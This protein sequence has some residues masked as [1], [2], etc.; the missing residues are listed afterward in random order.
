MKAKMKTKITTV[1]AGLIFTLTLFQTIEAQKISSKE[2][3][4][5]AYLV[6]EANQPDAHSAGDAFLRVTIGNTVYLAELKS[7]KVV[8][9]NRAANPSGGFSGVYAEVQTMLLNRDKQ[10]TSQGAGQILKLTG[11]KWKT[12][13][14]NE[15]DYQCAAVKSIPK[16]TLKALKVECN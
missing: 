6:K 7:G 2:T 15:S 16:A 14:R 10:E 5:V 8:E 3:S 12:I 13:A 9:Q 11:G 1:I 4:L